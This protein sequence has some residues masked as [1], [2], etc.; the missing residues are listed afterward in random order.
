M[1]KLWSFLRKLD[2]STASLLLNYLRVKINRFCHIYKVTY[3]GSD[4]VLPCGKY[5]YISNNHPVK[6][7]DYAA[8]REWSK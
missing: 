4:A 3:K 1:G 2:G 5:C 7:T 8:N 6:A